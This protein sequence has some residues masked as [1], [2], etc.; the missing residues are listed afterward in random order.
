MPLMLRYRSV[1]WRAAWS[2]ISSRGSTWTDC[3]TSD[4][5]VSVRVAT[6]ASS[7]LYSVCARP[8]TSTPSRSVTVAEVLRCC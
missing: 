2:S 4:N 5:G 6:A 1:I 3:G 7:D 8:T